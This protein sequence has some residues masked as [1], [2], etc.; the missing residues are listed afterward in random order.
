VTVATEAVVAPGRNA[1][2]NALFV[3]FASSYLT[4]DEG[5]AHLA[6]YEPIREAPESAYNR[7]AKDLESGPLEPDQVLLKLLPWSDSEANRKRGVW[8]HV[9][10]A[11]TGDL[12]AWF[13]NRLYRGR[14]PNRM[15]R[16][17]L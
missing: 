3:E 12:K 17:L 9:A 7:L 6:K 13:E 2:F 1:E 11:I 5:K 15:R 14:D 16:R 4:S 10:P 8:V